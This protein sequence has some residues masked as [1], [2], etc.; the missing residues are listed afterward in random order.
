MAAQHSK[1][2]IV[3]SGPAGLTAA[4]YTAR[5]GLAPV[6]FEGMQPGGQLTI[7]TEVENF[8]GF[9]EGILGPELMQRTKA[10]V[11]R[12]GARLLFDDVTSVEL[13][14]RPFEV[15]T[16]QS[17]EWTCDALIIASGASARLLGLPSEAELMGYGVSACA[18]CDGFFFR[19][20]EVVVVGGGDTAIEEAIFLTRFATKV[21]VIHR[22]AELR[23]SR[24]MQ[25]RAFANPKLEFAWN[26]VVT[27]VIGTRQGGVTAVRLRDTVTGGERELATQGVFVAIG[28]RPNTDVFRGKIAMDEVGYITTVAGTTRTSVDGVWACGDVQDAHYRQAITAAGTGCMAAIEAERWLA[29]RGVE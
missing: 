15:R 7:T 22:R 24:I 12:F 10:Q 28:H 27:E 4:L 5:A 11:E 18:T 21:T 3:G 23:A 6:V 29:A 8:P 17:G 25:Q 14:R 19:D 26:S 13:D 2:L 9:P 16:T 1:V 20:K